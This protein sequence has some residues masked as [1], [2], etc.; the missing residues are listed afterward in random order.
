MSCLLQQAFGRLCQRVC[1]IGIYEAFVKCHQRGIAHATEHVTTLHSIPPRVS[2]FLARYS[3]AL[4]RGPRANTVLGPTIILG[5]SISASI[6]LSDCLD[7]VDHPRVQ[8]VT[9]HVSSAGARSS[10][11]SLQK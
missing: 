3:S 1:A 4:N 5:L 6:Q 9:T 8:W 11:S 7:V 10:P 2:M